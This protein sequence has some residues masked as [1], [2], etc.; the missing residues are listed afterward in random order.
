VKRPLII[1]LVCLAAS[2]LVMFFGFRGTPETA[3]AP[4]RTVALLTQADTGSFLLQLR[5][6]AQAAADE[7][8]NKLTLVTVNVS[9]PAAQIAALQE[10]GIAAVLLYAESDELISRVLS[11]CTDT[12]LPVT[13]L[14]RQASGF[15]SASSDEKLAGALAV[16]QAKT[17]GCETF[18]FLAGDGVASERLSGAAD[19]MGVG[20]AEPATWYGWK[21]SGAVVPA[22]IRKSLDDGA[23]V[24]ALTGDAIRAAVNLL[25]DGT[26]RTGCVIIGVDSGADCVPLLENG[27]VNAMVLPAPYPMGY[28]GF[29]EA[30]NQLA[31]KRAAV[32]TTEP[33][34]IT[35]E[36]L[37]SAEVV[38]IAFPLIQ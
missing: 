8:G 14:D 21:D 24:I 26:L 38:K 20:P 22:E 27:Q 3:A 31:G 32:V 15:V 5:N 1:C 13:L 9:D 33:R 34:L 11:A 37:Y 35:P 6:G 29:Q 28:L 17:L 25:S 2:L 23:G 16:R 19:E 10:D 7:T 36:N 18:V 4:S 12:G 30:E